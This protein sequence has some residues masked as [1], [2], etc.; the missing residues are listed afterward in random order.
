MSLDDKTRKYFL[1]VKSKYKNLHYARIC[2]EDESR[3]FYKKDQEVFD[4]YF[5][6]QLELANAQTLKKQMM[7]VAKKGYNPSNLIKHHR[8]NYDFLKKL[9]PARLGYKAK[10][11]ASAP[12]L[13]KMVLASCAQKT[14]ESG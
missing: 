10:S 12:S 4:S 8:K 7:L 5:A 1:R 9:S 11:P 13:D 2:I 6:Y 3:P 14:P